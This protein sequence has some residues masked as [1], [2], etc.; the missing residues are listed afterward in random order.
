MKIL[1]KREYSYSCG[2]KGKWVSKCSKTNEIIRK[3]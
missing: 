1:L 3:I 2:E